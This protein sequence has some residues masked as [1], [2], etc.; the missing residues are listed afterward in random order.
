MSVPAKK[1]IGYALFDALERRGMTQTEAAKRCGISL[2]HFNGIVNGRF[3]PRAVTLDL[4]CAQL[5]LCLV[6]AFEDR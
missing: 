4:I 2:G 5:R 1:T 6:V 3:T